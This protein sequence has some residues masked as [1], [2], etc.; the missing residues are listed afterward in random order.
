MTPVWQVYFEVANFDATAAR[1]CALGGEQGFW[2]DAPNAGR[3]GAIVD[4][5]GGTFLIAQPIR[6]DNT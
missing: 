3:I 4:P 5:G 1:A 6:N 2:R